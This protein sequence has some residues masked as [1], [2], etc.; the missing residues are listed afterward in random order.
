MATLVN[1]TILDPEKVTDCTGCKKTDIDLKAGGFVRAGLS[2][3]SFKPDG[4]TQGELDL[5]YT[6]YFETAFKYSIML[7]FIAYF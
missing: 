3:L 4:K 7:G 2:W 5:L 6:H 1:V